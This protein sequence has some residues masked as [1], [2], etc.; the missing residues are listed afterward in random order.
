MFA[1]E[2]SRGL[3]KPIASELRKVPGE[4]I[5]AY[6]CPEPSKNPFESSKND[7]LIT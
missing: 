2:E 1:Y 5:A 3:T 7:P 6:K 4:F